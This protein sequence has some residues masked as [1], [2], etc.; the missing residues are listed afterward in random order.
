MTDRE[1][2]TYEIP[3]AG[4][5]IGKNRQASYEAAKQGFIPTIQVGP[6]RFKVPKAKWDRIVAGEEKA[7]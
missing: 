2:V 7:A 5:M 3:E 1:K 6:R 4:A